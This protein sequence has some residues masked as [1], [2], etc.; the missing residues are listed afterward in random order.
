M[1]SQVFIGKE[2]CGKAISGMGGIMK[3]RERVVDGVER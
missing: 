2:N 1:N 3:K